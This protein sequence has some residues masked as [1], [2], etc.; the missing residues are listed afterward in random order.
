MVDTAI[1]YRLRLKEDFAKRFN[2]AAELFQM[3]L[4]TAVSATFP[5]R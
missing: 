3:L 4:A 1:P 5:V 2:I